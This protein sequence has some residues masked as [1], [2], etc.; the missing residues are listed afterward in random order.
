MLLVIISCPDF[1]HRIASI[2]YPE[3][4]QYIVKSAPAT[5]FIGPVA[6]T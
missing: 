6:R 4:G 3:N 2:G 1:S 5:A